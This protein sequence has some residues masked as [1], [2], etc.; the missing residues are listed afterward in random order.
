MISILIS[1]GMTRQQVMDLIKNDNP[2]KI[3]GNFTILSP[4]DGKIYTDNLAL[5]KRFVEDKEDGIELLSIIDDSSLWVEASLPGNDVGKIKK[6]AN[7]LISS[8]EST[9]A[10]KVIQVYPKLDPIT[11]TQ[12]IIISISNNNRT[13]HS[14]EFVDCRVEIERMQ[15]A[16]VV[17]ES[18]IFRL[19]DGCWVVYEEI[20]PNHFKQTEVTLIDTI[21]KKSIIEGIESGSKIVTNGA[22]ALHSELLKSSFST[23]CH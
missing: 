23:K 3:T 2:S 6:G 18:S 19:A 10:G 5:G 14:G 7:V 17:P 13:L 8:S 22:F 11:R 12:K 15:H 21:G 9:L 4:Q 16:I 20:K 1:Y